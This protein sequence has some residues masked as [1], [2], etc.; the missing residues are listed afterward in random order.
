MGDKGCGGWVMRGLGGDEGDGGGGDEASRDATYVL[1]LLL[2]IDKF[3]SIFFHELVNSSTL[4]NGEMVDP[5]PHLAFVV[6][7]SPSYDVFPINE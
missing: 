7:R 5:I 2:F 4:L 3:Q 6:H 1:G